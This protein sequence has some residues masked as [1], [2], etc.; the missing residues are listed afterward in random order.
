MK[1]IKINSVFTIIGVVPETI[2]RINFI[3]KHFL[4]FGNIYAFKPTFFLDKKKLRKNPIK[5]KKD[6]IKKNY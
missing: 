6:F 5:D 1:K 2:N 3:W 4:E